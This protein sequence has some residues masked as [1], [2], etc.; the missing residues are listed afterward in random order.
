MSWT[1]LSAA[2]CQIW[3]TSIGCTRVGPL[4]LSNALLALGTGLARDQTA[5]DAAQWVK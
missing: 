2:V 1:G 4:R 3:R 5:A